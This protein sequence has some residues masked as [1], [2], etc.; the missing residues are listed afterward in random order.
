MGPSTI[1]NKLKPGNLFQIVL[2]N[3]AC[4][5]CIGR[6]II[7]IIKSMPG[8]YGRELTFKCFCK[9]NYNPIFDLEDDPIIEKIK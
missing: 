8:A 6:K 2:P 5:I 3:C 7:L 9:F 1:N 4:S